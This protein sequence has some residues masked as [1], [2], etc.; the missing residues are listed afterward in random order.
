MQKVLMPT[1]APVSNMWHFSLIHLRP[2]I[3][4]PVREPTKTHAPHLHLQLQAPTTPPP[5][6]APKNPAPSSAV[7]RHGSIKTAMALMARSGPALRIT[8][9]HGVNRTPADDVESGGPHIIEPSIDHI[10]DSPN[11]GVSVGLTRM[12]DHSPLKAVIMPQHWAA[13]HWVVRVA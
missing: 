8:N 10:I 5:S 9:Q 3:Q 12:T 2:A 7:T 11:S 1:A 6:L 4:S 13:G